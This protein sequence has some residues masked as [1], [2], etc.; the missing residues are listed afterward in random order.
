MPTKKLTKVLTVAGREVTVT[1]PQ[2]VYFPDIGVSK[3]EFVEYFVAVAD[4]AVRGIANR[5]IVLKRYVEGAAG[6]FFFQKIRC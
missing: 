6:K 1:N 5:P 2:K 4:G 3:L